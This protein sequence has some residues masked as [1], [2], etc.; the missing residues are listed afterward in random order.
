MSKSRRRAPRAGAPVEVPPGFA[1]VAA[2]FAG[3]PEVSG[4]KLMA[5]Y[6]L[7]VG[8]KIF[9]MLV[10]D[11][12]VAKLPKARADELVAGGRAEYFDPGHGRLMKQWVA[13]PAGAADWVALAREAHRFVSGR[14]T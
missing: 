3:D 8:G 5:S 2:A 14:A 4:G 9:A 11:A 1:L 12:L 13:V 7:K 6:G 10:N